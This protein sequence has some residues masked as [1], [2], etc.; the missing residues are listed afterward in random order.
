MSRKQLKAALDLVRRMPPARQ[1][2]TLASILTLVPKDDFAEE[3]LA[4]VDQPLKIRTCKETGKEFIICE[5]NRDADSFRSPHS[6]EYT[7]ELTDGVR[8]SK[9]LRELEIEMNSIFAVYTKQYYGDDGISSVYCWDT[10]DTDAWACS[11]LIRKDVKGVGTWNSMHVISVQEYPA[12]E[13]ACYQMTTSIMLRMTEKEKGSDGK[14]TFKMAGN[15]AKQWKQY[16]AIL[17]NSSHHVQN[18]GDYLQHYENKI[19]GNLPDLYFGKSMQVTGEVH[20]IRPD[21][22]VHMITMQA[23]PRKKK[24]WRQYA[25][26]NGDKYWYN[27]VTGETQ[28]EAPENPNEVRKVKKDKKEKKEKKAAGGD[29]EEAKAA[30]PMAGALAAAAM[31]AAQ[32]KTEQQQ[33]QP[34]ATPAKKEKK[35]KKAKKSG[36]KQAKAEDGQL[37]WYNRESGETSWDPPAEQSSSSP[38]TTSQSPSPTASTMPGEGASVDEVCAWMVTLGL[39]NDYSAS[40]RANAIDGVVLHS[41][42]EADMQEALGITAFGDKRKI[43]SQIRK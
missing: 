2:K 24:V 16:D 32:K 12:D 13:L 35:E 9:K 11:I 33:Q 29:L 36:W 23:K 1:T 4:D 3:L 38:A 18:I 8:P 30:N 25:D 39:A 21:A 37:Y 31:A 15:I 5:F 40:V 10:G 19:R 27:T 22:Q 6:N 41:L 34:D 14:Y 26:E 7:P 17:G 20:S 28:W 43:M 42:S